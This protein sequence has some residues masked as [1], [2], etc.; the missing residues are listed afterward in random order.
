M[1]KVIHVSGAKVWG[2]NEQQLLDLLQNF[3]NKDVKN[4]L[5]TVKSSKLIGLLSTSLSEIII[6]NKDKLKSF[7]NCKH[8]YDEI[9]RINPDIIHL[10]TSDALNLIYYTSLLY[11]IDSKII[12]EKKGIGRSSSFLS[13]FKYNKKAV[14]KIICVS[15]YV[16]D[17]FSEQL[18]PTN[19]S[20]IIVINDAI[21]TSLMNEAK[22]ENVPFEYKNSFIVGNIANHTSAK[23]LDLFL[24]VADIIINKYS[25]TNFKFIQVGRFSKLTP[26]L[27]FKVN[28]L[29]LNDSVSFLGEFDNA[30]LLNEFFDVFLLT[31]DREGGPT[32]VL[33][34]FFM[35]TPVIT[36]GVGITKQLIQNNVNGYIVDKN[37]PTEI[38]KKLL[39]TYR[40][41][42]KL[43]KHLENN[44]NLIKDT[45]SIDI[46]AK[47]VLDLYS[48]LL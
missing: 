13:K 42:H 38:A 31:S 41:P 43:H 20:K 14:D 4:Y 2:G 30:F 24:E 40:Q 45:L 15:N 8:F 48:S 23:N 16:A 18:S 25:I 17:K 19:K 22:I 29:G 46:K 5:Y 12:F 36:T 11:K 33:E 44:R 27:K 21:N 9:Q 39:E 6:S 34:A 28:E 7:K 26:Q 3:K 47:K 32:S 35:R 37:N 10:H 1:I